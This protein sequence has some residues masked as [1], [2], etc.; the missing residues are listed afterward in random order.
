MRLVFVVDLHGDEFSFE[1][2]LRLA[3]DRGASAILNGGDMLPHAAR[4]AV[5][6]QRGFFPWLARH[7]A[8]VRAAGIRSYAMFGNDDAGALSPL[9]DDL[10]R[11]GLV[12][13]LDLGPWH[14]L[15]GWH[16][17]G[18]PWVPDPP[19]RLKD[20]CRHD[21][22]ARRSP[23]QFGTPLFSTPA[24]AVERPADALR[25]LPT[26]EDELARLPAPPDPAR[27][28]LVAHGPPAGLGLDVCG[29][30]SGVGSAAVRRHIERSA[31]ALSLH[32]HIHE[33]PLRSRVWHARLGRTTCVQPGAL[34]RPAWVL[35]DLAERRLEHRSL[36][37]A[38]F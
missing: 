19:F 9:L 20:W 27:A 10:Q 32:G 2:A 22:G 6:V 23:P 21:D 15:G 25:A 3:V 12:R 24:G 18:F 14:D 29:D 35:V 28:I 38:P 7:F 26:I 16:V 11:D 1:E 36:G 33:S 30:G 8:A 5:A 37:E 13:R 31:F 17:L 4:G 34:D